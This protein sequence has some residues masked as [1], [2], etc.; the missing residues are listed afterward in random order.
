M[1][2]LKH[3]Y[4]WIQFVSFEHEIENRKTEYYKVLME[5]Q[6]NRPG[7]NINSWLRF[8][9]D[10][11]ISIQEKLMLKLHTQLP[12]S[13]LNPREKKIFQFIEAYPGAKSGEIALKLNI[14][15]PSVK[16]ILAG[17]IASKIISKN[18]TGA[19][20]NY[21]AEKLVNLKSDLLMKFNSHDTEK[22]FTL[23]N[24]HAYIHVKKII[25]TPKFLWLKPDD[26]AMH[27]S[28]QNPV[29]C[30]EAATKSGSL[31]SHNYAIQAFNS[32]YYFQPVF[33]IHNTLQIPSIFINDIT[34][35]N[36]YPI[37]IKFKLSWQGTQ[38]S[39]DVQL[40]YD[41]SEG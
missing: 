16:R 3:G 35:E 15:L 30:I 31:Y 23:P 13:V 4:H 38:L 21:T 24:K 11:L 28:N 2:L 17:M 22:S 25:L 9:L 1:L 8:F 40:V 14:P 29:L 34:N 32:P 12:Q 5:C 7:E 41:I 27:L 19:G 18:G 10:C 39:F 26:W 33:T 6:Q 20:T 36:E 37:N